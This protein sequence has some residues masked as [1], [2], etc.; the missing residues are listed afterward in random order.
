MKKE[1]FGE[2]NGREVYLYT[3]ENSHGMKVTVSSF[4]ALIIRIWAPDHNGNFADVALGYDRLE[5]YLENGKFYG[6]VVA[7]NANRIGG[8]KFTLEGKTYELSVNDNGNNLHSHRALGGHKRIW[9]AEEKENGILFTMSMKDGELGFGGNRDF[10]VLYE[11]TEEIKLDKNKK[12]NIEIVVDRLMVKPGIE[13]R[14]SDSIENVLELSKGLMT[15]DVID[16]EPIQ[17]S[18][19]F[20]CPDCGISIGEIEPRSFSFNNPFGACPTCFGLGYKMEFDVDLMIPDKRLSIAEGA[21]QV[22][23]WQS[24]TDPSSFTYAVL[25]ALTEEYHFSLET[26][27]QDYPDEIKYVILHGTDGREL[28]VHYK[29]MRGE[30]VYDVAFEGLIRNVQRKYRETGSETMKQEYEQFMRITPCETCKGQ[31]LKA[32]SLAVTVADKNIYEI[33]S[34]SVKKLGSFLNDLKLSHQQHLIGDQI[35]KEIRARVGFL[36]EV[37][38][39]YLSLS[40]ATGTL[41]GGEAQRIRLATQIGSGLVG[42]AYILDEPSIG[43]HQRDND[44]LLGAL[45]NLKDLGNTLIVVEHDELVVR[46]Q[47]HVHLDGVARLGRGAEGRER[48]FRHGAVLG[49]QA[50]VRI[51][52]VQKRGFLRARGAARRDEKRKRTRAGGGRCDDLAGSFPIH[53]ESSFRRRGPPVCFVLIKQ[54]F[55]LFVKCLLNCRARYCRMRQIR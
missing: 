39:D 28:K 12:H 47:V 33:T 23:G 19:S 18:E 6:A 27:F 8:A 21:I 44:K 48:V 46:R 13:K 36:N 31:R 37:G 42:V 16:G 10:S 45:K 4:G 25:K 24:C 51:I 30:G 32:E 11:L 50:A 22:M 41:S 35:L 20:S 55:L 17:F 1:L 14:L 2:V 43:L 5:Q 15:V 49:V 52:A 53:N 54:Q 40:R 34:M 7:P 38:L 9:D 3:L 26:P 29:G